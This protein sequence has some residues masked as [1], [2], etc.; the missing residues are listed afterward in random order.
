MTNEKLSLMVA[1][2]SSV[3]ISCFNSFWRELLVSLDHIGIKIDCCLHQFQL[4]FDELREIGNHDISNGMHLRLL[5]V[6]AR[7]VFVIQFP[8]QDTFE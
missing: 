6:F 7:S 5:T 8:S 1:W 2:L 3:S 4:Q